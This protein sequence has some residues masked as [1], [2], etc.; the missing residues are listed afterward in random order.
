[1]ILLHLFLS[2]IKMNAF[3]LLDFSTKDYQI[4]NKILIFVILL[5]HKNQN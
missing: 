5:I 3:N 1:M 4:L 2:K